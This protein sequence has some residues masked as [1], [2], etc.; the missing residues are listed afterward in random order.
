MAQPDL[1]TL[2]KVKEYLRDPQGPGADWQIE[3]LIS[4]ASS[5]MR[6]VTKRRFTS[7]RETGV[8]REYRPY[9]TNA[10]YI[11]EVC[12]PSDILGV[13]D[14]SG[15]SLAYDADFHSDDP[16]TKGATLTVEPVG[17]GSSW[18]NGG[19]LSLPPDHGDLFLR[20][21][22][23]PLVG[24]GAYP[25]KVLVTGNFGYTTIPAEIEFAAR[26][27]VGVWFKEEIARYT[28]DAFISRGRMFEPEALPPI[29]MAQLERT[30]W[31]VKQ[32]VMV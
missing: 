6:Q 29:T 25:R 7:P 23:V 17:Y 3:Q 4:S 9:G 24:I 2:T 5:L 13:T 10:V 18:S 14:E 16:L 11:D 30:G 26:R 21:L 15:I 31:I 8:L 19:L 12:S 22:S 32:P 28:A 27:T 1:T 20:E